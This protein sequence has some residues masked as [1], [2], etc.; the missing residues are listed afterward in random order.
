MSVIK[1]ILVTGGAGRLGNYV[2]PY[3][4]E[5]G[6]NVAA[7]DIIPPRPDSTNAKLRIPF[8]KADLLNIGDL[9]KAI[10]FSQA[11]MVV[12][13]GAI[14]GST[15]LQ[16][17]FE[18]KERGPVASGRFAYLWRMEEDTC[19]KVN[20]M[21]TF[22]VLDA[23]RRLDV[24]YC[25]AAS[26]YYAYGQGGQIAGHPIDIPSLPITEDMP[27]QPGDTYSLSKVLGEEIM[28]AYTRAYDMRCVAM[29]LNGVFYHDNPR[30]KFVYKFP[31]PCPTEKYK[32]GYLD[33]GL[34]EHVDSRD[35]ARFIGLAIEKID[36]LPNP[37]EAF[38]VWS[39]THFDVETRVAYAVK[40]PQYGDMVN[41]IQGYDGIFS[42]EKARRLLGYE[43]L[44]DWKK[45]TV[46]YTNDDYKK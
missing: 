23:C 41:N 28:K 45:G 26:S 3:L 30:A 9:M 38:N 37:F 11:D 14:T 15:E 17:P 19:M 27:C 22:Y 4:K 1:N 39:C 12:H 40:Y 8:I 33:G 21:G 18:D 29:R 10:A 36:E 2:C 46:D 31:V 6:Y 44:Y 42:I 25:I 34:E 24:K 43:P 35:I 32:E 5:L 16:R 20:T 13:L 7:T